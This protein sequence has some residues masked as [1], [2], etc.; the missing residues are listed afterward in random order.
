[1]PP[2]KRTVGDVVPY[3]KQEFLLSPPAAR[4]GKTAR[5]EEKAQMFSH[6]AF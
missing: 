1:M 3:K 4:G 2:H 5:D 6:L